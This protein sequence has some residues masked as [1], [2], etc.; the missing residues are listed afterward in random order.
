MVGVWA[1]ESNNV[2]NGI[3]LNCVYYSFRTQ[4][5]QSIVAVVL[6]P[7]LPFVTEQRAGVALRRRGCFKIHSTKQ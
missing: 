1:L 5:K 2:V 3:P 6:C 4:N 7:R